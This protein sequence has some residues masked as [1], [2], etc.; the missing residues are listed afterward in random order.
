MFVDIG[1]VKDALVHIKDVS[2]DYFIPNL[3]SKY[4]PGQM[5]DVWVKFV[6]EE[7]SKIGLQMYPVTNIETNL[8][9]IMNNLKKLEVGTPVLGRVSKVSEYGVFVDIGI[10]IDAYLHKRKMK[11]TRSQRQLKPWE[12]I[13]MNSDIHCFIYHVDVDRQRVA[14]TTYDPKDWDVMLPSEA[15]RDAKRSSMDDMEEEE[16]GGSTRAANLRA[17]QRTLAID[18]D[19]DGDEE[20]SE[21]DVSSEIAEGSLQVIMDD[22]GGKKGNPKS[23]VSPPSPAQQSNADGDEEEVSEEEMFMS[24]SNGKSYL[25]I[26]DLKKWDFIQQL[27]EEGIMDEGGLEDVFALAGSKRGRIDLN[28]FKEFIQILSDELDMEDADVDVADADSEG[29]V[30]TISSS[31]STSDDK[32]ED[33]NSTDLFRDS[34]DVTQGS[35]ASKRKRSAVETMS[36]DEEEMASEFAEL[37]PVPAPR[38]SVNMGDSGPEPAVQKQPFVQLVGNDILQSAFKRLAGRKK[39]ISSVDVMKW[40]YV[41]ALLDED[42]LAE[43]DLNSIF[44]KCCSKKNT[45][46]VSQF[47][48]F[49]NTVNELRMEKE[50]EKQ[51]SSRYDPSNNNNNNSKEITEEVKESENSIDEEGEFVELK[52]L[53]DKLSQGTK[54]LSLDT[55]LQSSV[56]QNLMEDS[57]M[58]E[59]DIKSLVRVLGVRKNILKY[60][61]FER[62]VET[63]TPEDDEDEDED[64]YDEFDRYAYTVEEDD[65]DDEVRLAEKDNISNNKLKSNTKPKKNSNT[66]HNLQESQPILSLESES[67]EVAAEKL[68]E[69]AMTPSTRAPPNKDVRVQ[70]END[71][72]ISENEG[73]GEGETDDIDEQQLLENVFRG[74][75]GGKDRVSAKDLL[76][77]DIVRNLMG[78]GL[79]TVDSLQDII[80]EC[81]GTKKGLDLESFDK[82]VDKLILFHKDLD[83]D[84][85]GEGEEEGEDMS[86]NE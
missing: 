50:K 81:G 10:S 13:P 15:E 70:S 35:T 56:F 12:I 74:L 51:S 26:R 21:D 54:K 66:L 80:V 57:E 82:M 2:T 34:A 47:I 59:D 75:S 64:E 4:Q 65:N 58:N 22:F 61:D 30:N 68:L 46:D 27:M 52:D 28:G 76:D 78:E 60:K 40:D 43:K 67:D 53:F 20:D 49:V 37:M 31:S 83:D 38:R 62:L 3:S 55:L 36:Q 84:E 5:I 16:L 18:I 11:I 9:E 44:M 7:T 41:K 86:G 45:L 29:T 17:V 33:V 48:N 71:E 72:A 25:A 79:L 19:A 39:S 14:L 32:N 1:T 42:S 73:E 69:K 8:I 6:D 24:L 85:E 63:I 77:W 23:K